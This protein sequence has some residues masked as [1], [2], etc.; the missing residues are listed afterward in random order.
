MAWLQ[1]SP[2]CLLVR[3]RIAR[4]IAHTRA[5]GLFNEDAWESVELQQSTWFWQIQ[6]I[7]HQ[8]Q[9]KQHHPILIY[10]RIHYF[11]TYVHAVLVRF[12]RLSCINKPFP[13][14]RTR[15]TLK[16]RPN[17][18]NSSTSTLTMCCSMLSSPTSGV[19]T[20]YLHIPRL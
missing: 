8:H 2:I 1:F 15:K 9:A 5:Y 19:S 20:S 10:E 16:F 11:H 3:M 6:N 4:L 18:E 7:H 12:F 17:V 14:T 13:D